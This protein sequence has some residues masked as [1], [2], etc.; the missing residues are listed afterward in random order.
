MVQFTL[1]TP[2]GVITE[3]QEPIGFDN[4]QIVLERNKDAHGINPTVSVGELEFYA[5]AADIIRNAYNTDID[6]EITFTAKDEN[7]VLYSGIIDLSFYSETKADYCSIKVKVGEIGVKTTFNTR[8]DTKVEL[9][10]LTSIDGDQLT[11]LQNLNRT[12]EVPSKTILLTSNTAFKLFEGN[13]K[14]NSYMPNNSSF[15]QLYHYLY[16]FP[17]GIK[18]MNEFGTI[19]DFNNDNIN[20]MAFAV[21]SNVLSSHI[22]IDDECIFI[23][24][25]LNNTNINLSVNIKLEL[26][27]ISGHAIIY[28]LRINSDGK[29]IGTYISW[30][31]TEY[32]IYELNFNNNIILNNNEKIAIII[33]SGE[34]F[35]SN[36]VYMSRVKFNVYPET[37]FKIT[38]YSEYSS[39]YAK[40]S[41]PHE[42]LSRLTE[43]I[44][45][46]TVKSDWYGTPFS[47][48]NQTNAIG[49]GAM[50]AIITGWD[51][52]NAKF[53][54]NE[55]EEKKL[56]LSMKDLFNS[57]N[58]ID[59]IGN[60]WVEE[61]GELYL[62]VE[63]WDWFY[64]P[65]IILEI[66]NPNKKER[67]VNG[68]RIFK[69][70]SIGYEKSLDQSQINSIDTFH[71][72]LN[73]S[74]K[75]KTLPSI[76]EKKSKFIAD[77]YAIEVT[78]RQQ[79]IKDTSSWT[80]DG[81]IFVLA[82]RGKGTSDII[83]FFL[84]GI[85][86]LWGAGY[87]FAG[88]ILTATYGTY[89][90]KS[91]NAV[92]REIVFVSAP[93]IPPNTPAA[94]TVNHIVRLDLEIDN[95]IENSNNT[96][97]SP[98]TYTNVRISPH[99]NALRWAERFKE[100][101]SADYSLNFMSG[102]G[103]TQATGSPKNESGYIY[104]Q[105]SANNDIISEN[106][107][108]EPPE[109]ILKQE[110]IKFT[111]P[112]CVSDYKKI[113][114]NPYGRIIVDGEECYI[115]KITFKVND[116]LADFE[117]IPVAK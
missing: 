4:L 54:E 5:V 84:A 72:T 95:G 81:D 17:M 94:F 83:V 57:L 16:K 30:N 90:V 104:L 60:G 11:P 67:E 58:A 3:I 27:A 15:Q 33:D 63:R 8:L 29:N 66:N 36:D 101:N 39:S 96:I 2:D 18:R 117:L 88:D 20:S 102:E 107:V 114:K 1:T 24:D 113:L 106:Q 22:F 99:R 41:L 82:L 7:E 23:N 28:I 21:G 53:I 40:F 35:L 65:E 108:I 105:D 98:Q 34:Q 37:F 116:H 6:T 59:N 89:T 68:D 92:T 44:C 79:F 70:I 97:I 100:Y 76:L 51:L 110:I 112:L 50:K 25:D 71:K 93:S 49:G 14:Y 61:N 56:S 10:Q 13:T 69:G 111:Y 78:R 91:F 55:Q 43:I 62:R 73:F 12:I 74:Q 9:K 115:S 85:F 19:N 42:G 109:P 45:G 75:L 32:K 47:D 103:N 38:S 48:V 80:F 52:R 26:L 86:R 31:L 64:K 46:K 87:L 77:P